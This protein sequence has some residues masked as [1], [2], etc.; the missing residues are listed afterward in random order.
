VDRPV[1][2]LILPGGPSVPELFEA[3]VTRVSVGGAI[4]MA[5]SAATIE[6]ARELLDAGTH[7]F[8]SRAI[9]SAGAIRTALSD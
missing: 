8:W 5:A 4:A 3:G 1:N 6:A 7:G 9:A 2:V